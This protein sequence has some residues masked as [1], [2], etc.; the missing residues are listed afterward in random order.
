MPS[1]S[2]LLT[3]KVT[4]VPRS[5]TE[6]PCPAESRTD[7][8]ITP[9]PLCRLPVR[10]VT[11]RAVTETVKSNSRSDDELAFRFVSGHRA[12]D[13]T[14]TFGDRYRDGVERLR[15]PAD[16]DRWLTA[17]GISASTRARDDDLDDARQLREVIYRVA[18]AALH[19]ETVDDK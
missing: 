14:T 16:L 11:Y 3:L 17:A 13:F 4:S 15:Q 10:L 5:D 2:S 1:A 19:N 7:P 12:L 18:H 6:S 9:P 8:A